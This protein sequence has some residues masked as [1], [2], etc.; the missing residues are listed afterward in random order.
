[1]ADRRVV[2]TGMGVVSPLGLSAETT[3]TACLGGVS[4][5]APITKFDASGFKTKFAAEVKDFDPLA[6]MDKKDAKKMDA[7]TQYAVACAKMALADAD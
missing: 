7:F 3:W 2:V 5:A 4:G 1:M 6:F